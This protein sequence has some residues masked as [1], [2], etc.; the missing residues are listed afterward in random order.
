ME[1]F[2]KFLGILLYFILEK[3][4][5]YFLSQ[6]PFRSLFPWFRNLHFWFI[7]SVS[8]ET[9]IPHFAIEY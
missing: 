7:K 2:I 9:V 4:H 8:D 5:I 3:L 1:Y 6:P